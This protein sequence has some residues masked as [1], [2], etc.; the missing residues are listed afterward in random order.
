MP[1]G[2]VVG[3][4]W[5]CAPFGSEA[6]A[7][8]QC[9]DVRGAI[10]GARPRAWVVPWLKDRPLQAG[11]DRLC[12]FARPALTF[13]CWQPPVR[14]EDTGRE[15]PASWEWLNPNH[16]GWE[17][18]YSRSD[19]IENAFVGG[20]FGCVQSSKEHHGIWCLGDDTYG[21]LGGSHPV[22]APDAGPTDPAFVQHLWP[23][24]GFAAG[25]WH[26]CTIAAPGGLMHES[27]VAC[28]GRGDHGQLG[29]PAPDLCDVG[30]AT[31]PCARSPVQGAVLE[32]GM[33]VLGA[34]DLF[35]CVTTDRGISCWGANR[36]GFF[37]SRA[38]C[39][40]R[41]REA[42]P[43]LHGNVNAPNA[44]CAAAPAAIAGANEFDQDFRV[45]PRG[46]CFDKGGATRCV[47]GIPTPRGGNVTSVAI[48]P[49]PD[50]SACGLRGGGVICWGEA[51][52]RAG[53]LGEPVSVAFEPWTEG[54]EAAVIGTT[55]PSEWSPSC[56]ARREC[57]LAA[58][59][60]VPCNGS[61]VPRDW[62]DVYESAESLAGQVVA[63]RGPLGVGPMGTTAAFCNPQ[64]GLLGCCNGAHARV[65][66]G[67][68]SALLLDGFTCTGD[69]SQLCCN[70]PAYGESVVAT[71]RLEENVHGFG[72]WK[73]TGVALCAE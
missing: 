53:A 65:M 61:L 29:A 73:L 4:R 20:S 26:A 72:E 67:G 47:G 18:S 66:L 24:E 52:S 57:T 35:T 28:W 55:K 71:G 69:D 63:V 43:T 58:P 13:R 59:S 27:H 3:E 15:L 22:P 38:S 31:V 5:G 48:S 9:W 17:E 19:R 41:L 14:G 42:W 8:W 1:T 30:G 45:G 49:G 40:D 2:V 10:P 39:P 32:N 16:A 12:S 64:H 70:A 68:T 25:T 6:G 60:L 51:Y 21:Q 56:L 36:D 7:T 62:A 23:A 46:L 34:G 33:A 37:G 44:A 11:P 54:P 50:A